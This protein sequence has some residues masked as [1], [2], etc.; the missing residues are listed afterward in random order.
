MTPETHR[1]AVELRGVSKAFHGAGHGVTALSDV[2]LSVEGGAFVVVVGHNGSGKST[3]LNVVGGTVSP[4]CG[5]ITINGC[6]VRHPRAR[7]AR[8]RQ[9]PSDGVFDNL[10]ILENFVLFA[11]Q[12]S[13]SPFR[14]AVPGDFVDHVSTRLRPYDLR[15]QLNR[16]V[17]D[18]SQGQRQ[19]LALE[20]AM[21]RNP[22]ILLL[23]EHT[24]SLDRSNAAFCMDATLELTRASGVTVLM[25]THK[26]D[27]ALKFGDTLL[28]MRD[29]Q[30][31]HRFS[32]GD[33]R[34]LS[35]EELAR[36]CGFVS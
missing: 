5:T 6:D 20:L 14:V 1:A 30:V 22:D 16:R 26:I 36:Y 35:V 10:T 17:A 28:V 29:G 21:S 11:L 32:E 8:V 9:T 33:K 23:D 31:Q 12:G 7:T 18:L 13:P 15:Q 27:E 4:D 3:L 25:V 34:A 2:T 19:I 24:A